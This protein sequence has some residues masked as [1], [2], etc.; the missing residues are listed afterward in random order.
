MVIVGGCS[1]EG[2]VLDDVM[3]LDVGTW[4]MTK[5]TTSE[6]EILEM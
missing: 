4:R 6:L 3:L 1:E 5:V 2:R